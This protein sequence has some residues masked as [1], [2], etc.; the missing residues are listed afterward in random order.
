MGCVFLG[1]F[2]FFRSGEF[3]CGNN[4]RESVLRCTDVSIDNREYPTTL[5]VTLRG[6]KTDVFSTGHTLHVWA[7]GESTCPV[8][9]VLGYLAVRP[10]VSGPLY[11]QKDGSSLLR[12]QMVA[13]VKKALTRAGLQE[14]CHGSRDIVSGSV[15]PPQ[16]LGQASP[17]P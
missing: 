7:T 6:S 10:L 2:T 1:F 13:E 8:T 4:P 9:A 11:V 5:T 3:V 16:L 17:I 12:P 14:K 15:Q